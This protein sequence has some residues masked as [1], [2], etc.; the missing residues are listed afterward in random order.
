MH[1]DSKNHVVSL[2]F[3]LDDL[4]LVGRGDTSASAVYVCAYVSMHMLYVP[5]IVSVSVYVYVCVRICAYPS[6]FTATSFL[7]FRHLFICHIS[8]RPF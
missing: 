4:R 6:H 7:T 2:L 5:I 1:R 8:I 3:K